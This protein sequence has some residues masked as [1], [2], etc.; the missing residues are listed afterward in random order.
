MR[1]IKV[2]A[3][4]A[5]MLGC[6]TL[7]AQEKQTDSADVKPERFYKLIFRAIETGGD[8]TATK[9]QSY[10]QIVS[11]SR[12][13][14]NE[15]RTG[16][17]LP[18]ATGSA[19]ANSGPTV[20]TQFQYIDVGTEIDTLNVQEIDGSVHADVTV[21]LS[22]VGK[23]SGQG[24]VPNEPIIRQCQWDAVITVPINKP[25]IIFSSDNPSDKGKTELELTAIP[26]H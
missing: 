5:V 13:K 11:D 4:L 9:G 22:S 24:S 10:S 20:V 23:P 16:D 15:I 12:G 19:S 26:I 3:L 14:R 17:K 21:K 1:G 25:T 7:Y 2:A 6:A 18:V 8:G